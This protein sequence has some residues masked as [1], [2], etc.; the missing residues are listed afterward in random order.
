MKEALAVILPKL[1][2]AR[3]TFKIISFQGVG[4]LENALERQLRALKDPSDRFL[5]MRD[6]DRGDCK[7]RKARLEQMVLRAGRQKQTK[8]R[9]VCEML[10]AWFVADSAALKRSGHLAKDAPARLVRCNPDTLEDPKKE[11]SRLRDGYNEIS[12]AKAIAPHLDLNNARSASF[13]HTI[14]AI[15]DLMAT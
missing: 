7:A 6:N 5:V 15:R 9:I 10:E 12:G 14:Q 8:V 1:G 11:L 3:G 4:N 2:A 13:R